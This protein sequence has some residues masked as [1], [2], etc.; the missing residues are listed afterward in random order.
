[1][2]RME[3]ALQEKLLAL[4]VRAMESGNPPFAAIIVKDGEILAAEGN[5]SNNGRN[6]LSHAEMNAIQA[7]LANHGAEAVASAELLA[8]NEP[9][10]MCIG[11][12]I[13]SGIKLVRYYLGQ[14]ELFAIRGWGR[15]TAARELA[16][17]NDPDM[18]VIGPIGNE[19][20]LR[21]HEV[22]WS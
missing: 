5:Y 10:P 11:A 8:T 4:Q 3:K 9:C 6:P 2:K 20:M 22:F 13:W 7:A 14:Q 18:K 1:M 19:M 16:L 21:N 17:Q 12:C 15:Y